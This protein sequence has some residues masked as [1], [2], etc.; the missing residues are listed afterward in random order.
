MPSGMTTSR[1][2]RSRFCPLRLSV[3]FYS[4]F[5]Y[6]SISIC[7]DLFLSLPLSQSLVCFIDRGSCGNAL[8]PRS[9][10]KTRCLSL[11]LNCEMLPLA[12]TSSAVDIFQADAE[13]EQ[14]AREERAE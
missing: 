3:S 4:L 7:F 14:R 11:S 6:L 2:A 10:L 12:S 13:Q 5:L 8:A 1:R 9:H